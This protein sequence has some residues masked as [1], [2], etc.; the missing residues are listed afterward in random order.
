MTRLLDEESGIR[1]AWK[2]VIVCILSLYI[3]ILYSQTCYVYI[4]PYMFTVYNYVTFGLAEA[5]KRQKQ[6]VN[7]LTMEQMQENYRKIQEELR[8]T[9][10]E[11][12]SCG[13]KP[14]DILYI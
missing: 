11:C 13:L 3:H 6:E 9:Q 10:A 2:A 4:Q 1:K 8:R 7:V 12:V 5:R 14:I